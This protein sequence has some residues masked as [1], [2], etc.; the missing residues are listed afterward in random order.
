MDWKKEL[1]QETEVEKLQKLTGKNINTMN[2]NYHRSIVPEIPK[3]DFFQVSN[4]A[5][6]KHARYSYTPAHTHH[7]IELNYMFNGNCTQRLNGETFHLKKGNLLLLDRKVIQQ[8][9]YV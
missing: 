6:T 2:L 1:F 9:Y 4:I 8:I 5:V 7:F 3:A